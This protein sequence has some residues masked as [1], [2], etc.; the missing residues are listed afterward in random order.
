M[1]TS[2]KV[3]SAPFEVWSCD[4]ATTAIKWDSRPRMRWESELGVGL[5]EAGCWFDCAPSSLP[6]PRH[7]AGFDGMRR[8]R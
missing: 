5:R 7:S 2:D 4:F 8:Y 1:V 3:G 6:L